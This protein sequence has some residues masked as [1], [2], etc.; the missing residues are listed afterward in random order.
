MSIPIRNTHDIVNSIQNNGSCTF[1]IGAGISASS[2]IP[3][4]GSIITHLSQELNGNSNLSE[5]EAYEWLTT[6]SFYRDNNPYASILDA[7][8]P[9]QRARITYFE[10]I[11]RGKKPTPAHLAITSLISSGFCKT[12]LTTNFDRLME[13]AILEM[14]GYFPVIAMSEDSIDNV[15]PDSWR[16]VIYKLHGDYLYRNIKNLDPELHYIK[17]NMQAK[18]NA[19]TSSKILLVAGYSGNDETVMD[20]L[21]SVVKNDMAF[22]DGIYW[23]QMAG[24]QLGQRVREF[25]ESCN[26]SIIEIIN[27]DTFF[28][29]LTQLLSITVD[30]QKNHPNPVNSAESHTRKL[31]KNDINKFISAVLPSPLSNEFK[32]LLQKNPM[33]GQLPIHQSLLDFLI[34]QFEE[35]MYLPNNI[36]EMW[37]R[38]FDLL[39]GAYIETDINS[40]N[41]LRYMSLGLS[42]IG[43]DSGHMLWDAVIQ[44]YLAAIKMDEDNEPLPDI[45]TLLENKAL[46][47]KLI[48]FVGL[49]P[50]STP[51]VKSAINASLKYL[52]AYIRKAAWSEKFYRVAALAGAST[53]ISK[54]I[55]H[56]ICNLLF[57]EFDTEQWFPEKAISS[58][59]ILGNKAIDNLVTYI[60]D[61]GCIVFSREDAAKALGK[62]GSRNAIN[63]L[64]KVV[65]RIPSNDTLIVY[66]IGLTENPWAEHALRDIAKILSQMKQQNLDEA[67]SNIG[68]T[69]GDIIAS[70]GQLGG[71][72]YPKELGIKE[73]LKTFCPKLP[74]RSYAENFTLQVVKT[75]LSVS[76]S[77]D[78]GKTPKDLETLLLTGTRLQQVGKFQEAEVLFWE[79]H[80]RYPSVYHVYHYIGM[81]YVA[82]NRLSIAKR[83]YE[84]GLSFK[85]KF[86]G[87]YNDFGLV[88]SE[89]GDVGAA[90]YLYLM[91]IVK[92]IDNH[93]PWFNL[94]TMYLLN[95]GEAAPFYNPY[96]A[97]ICF[98]QVLS[99]CPDHVKALQNLE[100]LRN[101][102]FDIPQQSPSKRELGY[103]LHFGEI[104]PSEIISDPGLTKEAINL[105][106]EANAFER[107]G[108]NDKGISIME[109]VIAMC[110]T[111]IGNYQAMANMLNRSEKKE[112][113]ITILESALH[114]HPWHYSCLLQCALFLKND[115]SR[116]EQALTMVEK[117]IQVEPHKPASW[118]AFADILFSRGNIEGAREAFMKAYHLGDPWSWT[119][120]QVPELQRQLGFKEIYLW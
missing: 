93:C 87:Y 112:A 32:L 28:Y 65:D 105:A 72:P 118:I 80:T 44:P 117:A 100:F 78:N 68:Y 84:I 27:S 108:D 94:G 119:I 21:N 23:L 43:L 110:P 10:S 16:A 96:E 38:Y 75:H 46:Y 109:Q 41:R 35:R 85:P 70:G 88:M 107:S 113:A 99:I 1:F 77:C 40:A 83:Y 18:I 19:T 92:K 97:I 24:H 15:N 39:V 50:D 3:S 48:M 36:G 4:A 111:V 116:S 95:I 5:E 60:L 98:R 82:M 104:I 71:Y 76:D 59:T 11:I 106:T 47:N 51:I 29:D 13:Y 115:S 55:V 34:S 37:D 52:S 54:S 79:A 30:N 74:K 101:S 73:V 20:A 26:G 69:K 90:R 61:T 114:I 22:T 89:L 7:R 81:L 25:L 9:S 64:S 102:G 8:F 2:G 6:Q 86:S 63:A 53:H 42:L 33:W 56:F 58:F 103:V 49:T 14:C 31:E 120:H 45:N 62:I 66:A 91:S 67:L 12:I 17:S 57:T